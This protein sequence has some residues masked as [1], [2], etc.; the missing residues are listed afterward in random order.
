RSSICAF[1]APSSVSYAARM[2]ANSV[3]PP[4]GFTTRADSSEYFAGVARN[5][6]SECQSMLPRLKSRTRDSRQRLTVAAEVRDVVHA[7]LR[8][9]ALGLVVVAPARVFERPK[10]PAERHLLLVG[11]LLVVEDEPRVAGHAR[12]ERR[13]LVRR[14]RLPDVD[15]GHLTH[16]HRVDL[17]DGW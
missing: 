5:E 9:R 14:Q 4:A 10:V 11:E 16:E 3:L 7:R 1:V 12:L 8:A 6:L 13:H 2:S 17:A 15:P